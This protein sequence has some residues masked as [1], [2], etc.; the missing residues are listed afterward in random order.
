MGG[1]NISKI[2]DMEPPKLSSISEHIEF[3]DVDSIGT[4]SDL[5]CRED[6]SNANG[7][8]VDDAIGCIPNTDGS[9]TNNDEG[10]VTRQIISANLNSFNSKLSISN[11]KNNG[12]RSG[13]TWNGN[14]NNDSGDDNVDNVNNNKDGLKGNDNDAIVN[15]NT[16]G[17]LTEDSVSL[18]TDLYRKGL[19][20]TTSK[21]VFIQYFLY[22]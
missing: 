3:N 15:D 12:T 7:C 5:H 22:L 11:D 14:N 16:N 10:V 17:V 21:Q 19:I 18:S 13:G 8:G 1:C 9:V 6:F 4:A 2:G 20:S